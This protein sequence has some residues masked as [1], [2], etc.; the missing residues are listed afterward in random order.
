MA[1]L[2]KQVWEEIQEHGLFQQGVP[3]MYGKPFSSISLQQMLH[4]DPFF[5]ANI[6]D[7]FVGLLYGE[8]N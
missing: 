2:D 3:K 5:F 1:S 4:N 8:K 7:D 6:V